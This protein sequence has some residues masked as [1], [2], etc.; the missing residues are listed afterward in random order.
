MTFGSIF[1]WSLC[2]VLAFV[3]AYYAGVIVSEIASNLYLALVF[4]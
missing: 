2:I 1:L 3:K 4:I